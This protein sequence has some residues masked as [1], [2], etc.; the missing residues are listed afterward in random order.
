MEV[1]MTEIVG[2][3]G[4]AMVLVSFLMKGMRR[5]R[6]LNSFG[7]ALFVVYGIMLNYSIPIILT[8]V[9]ILTINL[10]VLFGRKSQ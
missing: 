5:L 3:A 6:I 7:C 10:V 1:S 8:N 2:Y 4:S 9:A